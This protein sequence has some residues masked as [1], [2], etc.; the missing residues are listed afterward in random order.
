MKT[1][2]Q[3]SIYNING[4]TADLKSLTN[5][6]ITF[7]DFW[8]I[9]CGGCFV[10]MHMLHS[11]YKKYKDNP[12]VSFL[13]ITFTDTGFVRP[14]IENRLTD[15]NDTYQY[16]KELAQ[17]DSFRLPVY[18][19]RNVSMKM[20]SLKKDK[21]GI[22]KGHGEPYPLN[23]SSFPDNVFGFPAYP[24]IFIFDK[25][26]NEFYTKTGFMKKEEVQQQKII[27]AMINARL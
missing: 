25:N 17:L 4:D 19:I 14:L 7:I 20:R 2:P 21:K 3:L 6:K 11:L 10:E 24:T 16:F 1:T 26:G 8:F 12:N 13:T 9:P 18:F 27:E 15:S 23:S 5:G 22:F